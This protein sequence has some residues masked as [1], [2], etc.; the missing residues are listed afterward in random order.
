MIHHA[1]H[2]QRLAQLAHHART[3]RQHERNLAVGGDKSSFKFWL[4]SNS[5][6]T[7]AELYKSNQRCPIK[8]TSTL[9]I[10]V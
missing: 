5:C 6:L 10:A 4:Y 2:C 7:E 8:S 9:K 1:L 3:L